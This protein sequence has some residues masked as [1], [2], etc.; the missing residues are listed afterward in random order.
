MREPYSRVEIKCLA[1]VKK[2]IYPS[3][4]IIIFEHVVVQLVCTSSLKDASYRGKILWKTKVL[5]S[6]CGLFPLYCSLLG[7]ILI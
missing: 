1:H 2:T 5:L 6:W 3:R 7:I 4:V